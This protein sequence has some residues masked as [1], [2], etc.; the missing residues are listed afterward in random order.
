M[1]PLSVSVV[2]RDATSVEDANARCKQLPAYKSILADYPS[3][4]WERRWVKTE[5]N[6][7]NGLWMVEFEVK[8]KT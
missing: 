5:K 4:K 2:V 3:S 1:K 6:A 7:Q 8:E